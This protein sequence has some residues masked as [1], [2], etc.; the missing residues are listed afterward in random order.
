[1]KLTVFALSVVVCLA[2]GSNVGSAATFDFGFGESLPCGQT[3]S[4]GAGGSI[5]VSGNLTLDISDMGVGGITQSVVVEAIDGGSFCIDPSRTETCDPVGCKGD[6]FAPTGVLALF[7]NPTSFVVQNAVG[8]CEN[9]AG[10][11][12]AVENGGRIGL[13]DGTVFNIGVSLPPG[14]FDTLPVD[15]SLDVPTDAATT[16]T[17]RIFY[18]DELKATGQPQ[19]NGV[20]FSGATVAGCDNPDVTCGVCEIIIAVSQRGS[21]PGDADLDGTNGVMDAISLLRMIFEGD[22]LPCDNDFSGA[23]NIEM[24]D[25]NG[26]GA[27]DLSDAI[28]YMRFVLLGGEPP[29]GGNGDGACTGISGAPETC[30]A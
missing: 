13:V 26:D 15:F 25:S 4:G 7:T 20:S 9:G 6:L 28:H 5:S 24:L 16:Y 14:K 30:D 17:Y 29:A 23:C 22:A 19:K 27:I 1:M 11:P 18:E 12:D 10:D 2:L 3:L 8:G 21:V